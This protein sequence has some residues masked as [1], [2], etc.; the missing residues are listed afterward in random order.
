MWPLSLSRS[1]PNLTMLQWIRFVHI[2]VLY[3]STTHAHRTYLLRIEN[4]AYVVWRVFMKKYS[5]V[6]L[7]L[8]RNPNALLNDV[9]SHIFM[10]IFIVV[11]FSTESV[12]GTC[13]LF[14]PTSS[15]MH[16][17]YITREHRI[18]SVCGLMENLIECIQM[19]YNCA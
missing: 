4:M 5:K 12:F 7:G 8:H 13:F 1:T 10:P 6:R 3:L 14:V 18:I 17:A 11:V 2:F 16:W 19:Q 15:V 9:S